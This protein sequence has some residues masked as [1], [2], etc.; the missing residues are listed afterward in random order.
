MVPRYIV[1]PVRSNLNIGAALGR[2]HPWVGYKCIWSLSSLT[3]VIAHGHC[4]RYFRHLKLQEME[5][6]ASILIS[7]VQ[8]I[9]HLTMWC[10]WKCKSQIF[11]FKN[12]YMYYMIHVSCRLRGKKEWI[13]MK[14][15]TMSIET[16]WGFFSE[17]TISSKTFRKK[18]N[19]GSW[20]HNI[21]YYYTV[22]YAFDHKWK[23]SNPGTE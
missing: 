15:H 11:N 5:I 19:F 1:T 20:I 22:M 3:P 14:C 18:F 6:P 17:W 7:N 13:N 16:I 2:A 8:I 12:W 23:T 4:G 21:F 10:R 9:Q